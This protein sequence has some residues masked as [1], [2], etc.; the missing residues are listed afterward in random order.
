MT[1]EID[2]ASVSA[3]QAP[4]SASLKL[5]GNGRSAVD[6]QP[7]R[8]A[9]HP[10][11]NGAPNEISHPLPLASSLGRNMSWMSIWWKKREKCGNKI[12]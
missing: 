9:P 2:F 12:I 10:T 11:T 3:L 7:C 5:Q 4:L 1:T 8:R 6:L